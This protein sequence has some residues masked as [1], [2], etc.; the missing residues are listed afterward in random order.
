MMIAHS[1][2]GEMQGWDVLEKDDPFFKKPCCNLTVMAKPGKIGHVGDVDKLRTLPG[3]LSVDL[4]YQVG[5]EIPDSGALSQTFARVNLIADN[6][7]QLAQRIGM[8]YE[9]IDL[10]L[11]NGEDQLLSRLDQNTIIHYWG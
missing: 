2:T 7:T 9:I 4:F 8:T 6:P 3:V 1:L 10:R 5:Q 11:E